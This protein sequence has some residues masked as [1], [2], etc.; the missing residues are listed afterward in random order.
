MVVKTGVMGMEM[1]GMERYGNPHNLMIGQ[2]MAVL[3]SK[4]FRMVFVYWSLDKEP[5]AAKDGK[6]DGRLTLQIV[7]RYPR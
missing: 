3:G 6:R 7:K 2:T 1:A 4:K 5:K